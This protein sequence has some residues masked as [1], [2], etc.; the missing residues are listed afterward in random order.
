M[1]GGG[2]VTFAAD[3]V[4]QMSFSLADEGFHV[5]PVD[6]PSSPICRGAH[7]REPC[8]GKRGKHP[9]GHWPSTE[10]ARR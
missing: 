1:L 2:V 5:F 3:A 4:L 10:E 9:I 7:A 6:H 8:N